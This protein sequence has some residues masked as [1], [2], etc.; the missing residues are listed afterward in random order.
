[1]IDEEEE[2]E[3]AVE[4]VEEKDE[5]EDDEEDMDDVD[6]PKLRAL[7]ERV[8]KARQS[9]NRLLTMVSKL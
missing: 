1:M 5:D 9:N 8:A 4:G 2:E 7:L 3:E 6:D